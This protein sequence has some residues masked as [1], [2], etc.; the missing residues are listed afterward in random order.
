M[1]EGTSAEANASAAPAASPLPP[2]VG[3]G[4]HAAHKAFRPA[5]PE[6]V[7]EKLQR[8]RHSPLHR[9]G[10][11]SDKFD[12]YLF[13][14]FAILGFVIIA[15]AKFFGIPGLLMAVAS[16]WLLGAY[17]FLAF[18]LDG[19]KAN[20]EGLGDNCYYMGFLFTLGSLSAA[21]VALERETASGRGDLLEALIGSFGVAL[22]STIGGITLRVFFMHMRREIVDLEQKLR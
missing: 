3:A 13:L 9:K 12:K 10:F 16:L 2:L 14:S 5:P 15:T 1:S 11:Y 4:D 20:P 8:D 6:L 17:A 22:F 19:F 18:Q 21:L 7:R